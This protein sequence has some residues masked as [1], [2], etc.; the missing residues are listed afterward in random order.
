MVL[1]QFKLTD[2][3][4]VVTGAGH[5]I[6]E[7]I[8][9]AFTEAGAH[10]VCAARTESSI[11]DTAAKVRQRGRE[12][13]AVRCDVLETEQIEN[14]VVSW[15]DARAMIDRGEIEHAKTLV[16]LMLVDPHRTRAA[17]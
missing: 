14:L 7:G 17:D 2:R 9:L 10:I 12:S 13:L 3:V 6:G 1:D 8:A 16:G 11:D 5:G 4:A 15:S